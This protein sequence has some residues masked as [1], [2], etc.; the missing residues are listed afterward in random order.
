[1]GG[2][3]SVLH[4]SPAGTLTRVVFSDGELITS[5]SGRADNLINQVVIRTSLGSSYTVG[6]VTGG[7]S[8]NLAFPVYGFFGA[9]AFFGG[10]Y[11]VASLGYWTDASYRPPSPPP[12]SSSTT[13]WNC[14]RDV[15]SLCFT[16]PLLVFL[17]VSCFFVSG[18][19]QYLR[20]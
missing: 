11:T 7:F 13:L 3:S 10:G 17:R 20:R 9:N 15:P 19:S 8:F 6:G 14:G 16:S 5:I 2:V 1:M 12:V 4:G 18:W